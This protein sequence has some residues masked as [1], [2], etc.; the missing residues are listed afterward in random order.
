MSTV[1]HTR[2]PAVLGRYA[3]YRT[4]FLI[5]LLGIV[6]GG[7]MYVFADKIALFAWDRFHTASIALLLNRTNADLGLGIGQYHFGGPE[8]DPKIALAASPQ[9]NAIGGDSICGHYNVGRILFVEG[10]LDEARAE[11]NAERAYHPA[12]RRALYMLGLINAYGGQL[13][14]AEKNFREFVAWAPSEWAGYNDLAWVLAQEE[15]YD[16][17]RAILEE[18]L[19]VVP[20]AE[21]NPWLWN[22]LGV[23]NLNL[24]RFSEARAQFLKAKGYAADLTEKDWR[25]AYPGNDPVHAKEG[26]SAFRQAIEKNLAAASEGQ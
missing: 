26:I 18:A 5:A 25:S 7:A 9:A 20:D 4:G 14:E 16:E 21:K 8:Y 11:M 1:R 3:A 19:A 2:I 17:A 22:N 24:R 6:G 10:R 23:Q 13:A 15:K 12:N